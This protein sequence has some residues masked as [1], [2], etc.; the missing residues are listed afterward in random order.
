MTFSFIISYPPFSIFSVSREIQVYGLQV[1]SLRLVNS[2]KT[3]PP[4]S[5]QVGYKSGSFNLGPPGEGSR[6]CGPGI[7]PF[8]MQMIT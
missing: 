1:S 8:R 6:K 4:F 2:A 7:S 3:S 5:C